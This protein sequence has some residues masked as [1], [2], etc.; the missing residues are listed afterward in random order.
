M[1]GALNAVVT[2]SAPG[3]SSYVTGNKANNNTKACFPTT[4]SRTPSTTRGSSIWASSCGERGRRIQRRIVT[5]ADVTDA[6]PAANAVHTRTA[7]GTRHRR[8]VLRREGHQRITV[9]MGGGRRHFDPAA[10]ANRAV[11]T[12][13]SCRRVHECRVQPGHDG[14]RCRNGIEGSA[15]SAGALGAVPSGHMTVA[16]D[17]VGAGAT[18]TNWRRRATPP[19]GISRC[20][21]T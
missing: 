13:G 2:D 21:T 3:M 16:F 12:R 11:T 14:R 20:S 4:R 5:T 17:K 9:L 18:A 6:T 8:P 10:K 7:R 19:C 1:T 15:A